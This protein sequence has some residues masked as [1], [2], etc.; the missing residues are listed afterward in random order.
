[1]EY[2]QLEEE[3]RI[4]NI[5]FTLYSVDV[6]QALLQQSQ[7]PTQEGPSSESAERKKRK[8]NEQIFGFQ[9]SDS[10]QYSHVQNA[11]YSKQN[12]NPNCLFPLSVCVSA[13]S[14]QSYFSLQSFKRYTTL[15]PLHSPAGISEVCESLNSPQ[16]SKSSCSYVQDDGVKH[17]TTGR[18]NVT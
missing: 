6:T 12:I 10:L 4:L 18:L 5:F 7:R 9:S 15:S 1:M 3:N 14:L 17:Y 16:Q 13:H 11:C 8:S 2:L